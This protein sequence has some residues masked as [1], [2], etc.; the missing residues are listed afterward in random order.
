MRE[1]KPSRDWLNP[2]LNYLKT[3]RAKAKVHHWFRQCDF[4]ENLAQ[5]KDI[6]EQESKRLNL[7]I[8][9]QQLG[10][11]APRFNFKTCDDLLAALGRS[12][13]KISQILHY[14][15]PKPSQPLPSNRPS[16]RQDHGPSDIH[17][18]GIGSLLSQIAHCC[19]PLPGEPIVG[20]ITVGRGVTVHRRDCPNLPTKQQRFIALSWNQTSKEFY[21]IRLMIM[22]YNRRNLL[23]DI[24]LMFSNEKMNLRSLST[25]VNHNENTVKFCATLEVHHL[26]ELKNVIDK[27]N[28]LPN[29]I[30]VRRQN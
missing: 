29:M 4:S 30:E 1:Q 15:K 21:P 13:I 2:H 11:L 5:G 17:I 27:L 19:H 20:Y 23:R 28:Q 7:D 14:L 18:E 12:D 22:A 25:A 8:S 10:Q 9:F 6:F 16:I 24:T 3:S 26:S